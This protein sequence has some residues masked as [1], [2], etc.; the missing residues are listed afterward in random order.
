MLHFAHETIR[1]GPNG[2]TISFPSPFSSASMLGP[3]ASAGS[4]KLIVEPKMVGYDCRTTSL[5]RVWLTSAS[6]RNVVVSDQF[7]TETLSVRPLGDRF[8]ALI[9][10]NAH[11]PA[12]HDN[13]MLRNSFP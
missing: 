13:R 7:K 3:S 1:S 4:V 12:M 6:S 2:N 9:W 5:I 11:G 8:R 10:V